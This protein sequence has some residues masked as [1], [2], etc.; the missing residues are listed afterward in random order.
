[1]PDCT[2]CHLTRGVVRDN[3]HWTLAVNENQATL[4][5]VFFTLKRHETDVTRLTPDERESLWTFL[6]ETKEALT[7]LF[8][9][10]HFNYLFHM[11]LDPHCHMH[12][13]PRYAGAREFAGR[14]F[15][16]ARYGDHYDPWE[17][18]PLGDATRDALVTALRHELTQPTRNCRP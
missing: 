8:A 17:S 5:R 14:T 16:D 18:D 12:I 13:Y 15:T 3:G 7:A 2:L 10:D 4:G 11:N 9:P 6:A 1:M